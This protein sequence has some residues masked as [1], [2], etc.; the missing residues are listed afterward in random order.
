MLIKIGPSSL[1][2]IFKIQHLE[3]QQELQVN[4]SDKTVT[5]MPTAAGKVKVL[6]LQV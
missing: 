6:L 1:F 2:N 4:D 3:E 5:H